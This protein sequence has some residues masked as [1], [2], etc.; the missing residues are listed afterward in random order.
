MRSLIHRIT[1]SSARPVLV[2]SVLLLLLAACGTTEPQTRV[3]IQPTRIGAGAP[4]YTATPSLT[5]SHTPT[6][7]PTFTATATATATFTPSHTPTATQTPT[8][9]NTPTATPTLTPSP[10]ETPPL[11]TPTPATESQGA[12]VATVFPAAFSDDSGWSC[13][14]F[15]CE[16]DIDNW[17]RRVQVPP[18]FD[19]TFVGSFPGQVQQII[20]GS[21]GRIYAT[22]LENGTRSG[23]VYGMAPGTDSDPVRLSDTLISPL[24][25]AFRPGTDTLYVTARTE[26]ESGGAL[27]RVRSN[28]NTEPV[29]T[30]LPCCYDLIGSQPGGV[31]FGADGWLYLGVGALT[32]HAE[33]PQPQSQPYASVRDNEAAVLRV[34]PLT[35]E[36]SVFAEGIRF[37]YDLAFDSRGQLYATDMG[38]VTGEGDR[39]LAVDSNQ[40]YG[41]PYYRLRGCAECPP[42]R[43]QLDIA[44][45]LLTLPNYT[46]PHGLTVYR[47]DNFPQNMQNTLF[48]AFW[49][50]T[51]QAQRIVW[52]D[53]ASSTLNSDSYAPQ[54]F[55]TGLVRPVDVTVA[56]DGS[57]LVADYVYGHIWRVR[58]S[59]A[60]DTGT[61]DSG[62]TLPT[63]AA[64]DG[65]FVTST[66]ATD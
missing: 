61:V 12:A 17:L 7:T 37:P 1:F 63:A 66:P 60:S 31:T 6:I 34:N 49:N 24:G 44:P 3:T 55:V 29:L 28:G 27:Y 2:Y 64:S 35:G 42:T 26:L 39:L 62:F 56:P 18:G 45:D 33:S 47:G 19:V 11:F 54:P 59:G 5:P 53:P 16:D 38:L 10:T 21:D 51:P 46:L 15:P 40:N 4:I 8:S 50:D 25:L 32:D 65:A 36:Y 41:W 22:V 13:G 48:V 52:I 14:D 9:T 43:G 30:D 58:Y 23:A 20:S 57:L